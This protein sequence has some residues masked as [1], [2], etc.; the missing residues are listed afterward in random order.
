MEGALGQSTIHH[1]YTADFNNAI[2]RG[3]IQASS[4]SI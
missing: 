4:F 1:F 3:G 2:A